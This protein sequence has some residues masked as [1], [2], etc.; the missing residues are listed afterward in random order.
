MVIYDKNN[1]FK[2]GRPIYRCCE[3]HWS[4]ACCVTCPSLADFF[5]SASRPPGPSAFLPGRGSLLCCGRIA[6]CGLQMKVAGSRRGIDTCHVF[7]LRLSVNGPLGRSH[8]LTIVNNAAVNTGVQGSFEIPIP[9][10]QG[11]C[12]G[13]ALRDH[14]AARWWLFW[15]PARCFPLWL[16]HYIPTRVPVAV[17]PRQHLLSFD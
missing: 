9:F 5:H 7:S 16:C 14:M 10:L 12:P 3:N 4:V 2:G 8:V 13:V 6:L 17:H 11:A 1:Q 15:G